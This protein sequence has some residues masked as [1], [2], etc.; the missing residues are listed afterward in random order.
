MVRFGVP[1][2]DPPSTTVFNY[3][4]YL[5][6]EQVLG[7]LDN[8]HTGSKGLIMFSHDVKLKTVQL[9]NLQAM[10]DHSKKWAS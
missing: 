10:L 1:Q 2:D 6:A 8:Y 5:Y 4:M 9:E 7:I 3:F